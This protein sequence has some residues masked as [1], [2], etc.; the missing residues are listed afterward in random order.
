MAEMSIP[1]LFFEAVRDWQESDAR[2][3]LGTLHQASRIIVEDLDSR[4]P[5]VKRLAGKIFDA[6]ILLGDQTMND[7]YVP[8]SCPRCGRAE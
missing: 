4:N 6:R 5:D 3:L 1:R 8:P 2:A 7:T